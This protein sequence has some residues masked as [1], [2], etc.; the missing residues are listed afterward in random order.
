MGRSYPLLSL[1]VSKLSRIYLPICDILR[2]DLQNP[3]FWLMFSSQKE[4]NLFTLHSPDSEQRRQL[5]ICKVRIL[6]FSVK[7]FVKLNRVLF[8]LNVNKLSRI[9]L[10][11]CFIV[12]LDLHNPEKICLG[13]LYSGKRRQFSIC[14]IRAFRQ[15]NVIL[16]ILTVVFRYCPNER[17]NSDRQDL[18]W[19]HPN[20]HWFFCM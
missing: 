19:G 11:I 9:Y 1:N 13:T 4:D 14:K 18:E 12:R 2:L 16:N 15:K 20:F 10:P 7:K 6:S 3:D 17:W 8:S 5:S